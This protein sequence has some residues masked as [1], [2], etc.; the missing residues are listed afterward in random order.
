VEAKE[1]IA[2]DVG[3]KRT[4]IARASSLVKL[5]QALKSV[6]TEDVIDELKKLVKQTGVE[7]LVIGLPRNLSGDDTAQTKWVRLWTEKAKPQLKLPM[8]W[9]D[10]ALTSSNRKDDHAEAAAAILQDFLDTPEEDRLMC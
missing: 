1:I 10:E 7:L 9:Q 8:Y 3:Q 6:A 4:G 2:L 5:P